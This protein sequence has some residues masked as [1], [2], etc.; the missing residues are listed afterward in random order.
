MT[1]AL[2]L[3]VGETLLVLACLVVTFIRGLREEGELEEEEE[4]ELGDA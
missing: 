1:I 3:E 2:T 4:G